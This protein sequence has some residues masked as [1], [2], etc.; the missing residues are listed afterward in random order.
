MITRLA[1]RVAAMEVARLAA[2]W[3]VVVRA[4][5]PCRNR[6]SASTSQCQQQA[7]GAWEWLWPAILMGLRGGAVVF[8]FS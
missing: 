5:G 6:S 3:E 4:A 1:G 8:S 7:A 2:Q